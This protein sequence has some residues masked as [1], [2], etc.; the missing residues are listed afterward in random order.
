MGT[1]TKVCECFR[2]KSEAACLEWSLLVGH[3][4]HTYYR[5]CPLCSIDML[6]F[7]AIGPLPKESE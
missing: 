7:L 2:C 3:N 1:L 5:L 4:K 6:N